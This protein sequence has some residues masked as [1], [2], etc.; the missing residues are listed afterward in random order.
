MNNMRSGALLALLGFAAFASHDAVIKALGGTYP[1]FQIAFFSV[2]FG[3]P[4][5][6]L[7]LLADRKRDT[8]IPHHPIWVAT[9]T[10]LGV[11]T[12]FCAFYAFTTLPLAEVYAIIFA[13]PLL[14]TAL[15]VPMLGERVGP[16]RWIAVAV[17]L[18][19]VLIVMQ[20]GATLFTLGHA[21]ALIAAVAGSFVSVILR[22]IGSEERSAVMILYPM[23][24]NLVVMGLLMPFVYVPM[25]IADLGLMALLAALGFV[26]MLGLL[27]AYR[28][29]TASTVA[30][31]Q[32][33]Q[34]LWAVLFGALFFDEW[35][36]LSTLAGTAVIV[37]SGLY[38]VIREEGG[39]TTVARPVSTGRTLRGDTA[40]GI[41][42]GD[43]LRMLSRHETPLRPDA[44]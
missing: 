21:A 17:G 38:I 14:I 39:G 10:V 36:E 24:A 6:V 15:S 19:G 9:R 4:L 41:R 2:L 3:F 34:I 16:R 32:Y 33:S 27:L 31:M 44:E 35:P 28:R 13:Q 12:G 30:P 5:A 29:A 25:P 7:M 20:P 26:G 42:T 8:L 11:I 22:R 40:L 18:V 37:A 43:V 23:V 1:T